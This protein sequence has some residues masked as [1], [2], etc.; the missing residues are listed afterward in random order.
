MSLHLAPLQE[1]WLAEIGVDAQW[2]ARLRPA[3]IADGQP[4]EVEAPRPSAVPPPA[5]AVETVPAPAVR[6]PRAPEPRRV[7][8]EAPKAPATVADVSGLDDLPAVADRIRECEVCALHVG[9]SHAVP[10]AGCEQAPEYLIVGEMPGVEDDLAGEPFQGA[11]GVLL[12]AMLASAG[13]AEDRVF[14]TNVIRCRPAGGRSPSADEVASCLP[15][16]QRQISILRPQRILALGRLAAQALLGSRASLAGLRGHEQHYR[17]A[18]GADIPVWVT[19]HP[20]S[21]LLRPSYKAEAWRDL[22]AMVSVHN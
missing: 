10:G 22:M 20:A 7:R 16:L 2:L 12:R 4:R 1:A 3:S 21:L 6:A 14:M 9:R 8:P 11:V 18:D 13:V 17:T 15:Y 19:H 5:V